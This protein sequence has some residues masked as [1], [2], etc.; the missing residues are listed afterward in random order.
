M[1]A[2]VSTLKLINIL[3]ILALIAVLGAIFWP[4]Y[5]R[6][7]P[8]TPATFCLSN[9]KQQ[10][11]AF[12]MYIA[13]SDEKFPNRDRWMDELFPYV[14]NEEIYR[15]PLWS[16]AKEPRP[17][18]FAFNSRL[19]NAKAP[20]EIGTTPVVYDSVNPIRNASDPAVSLPSP[21][22]HKGKNNIAYADGHAKSIAMGAPS[23]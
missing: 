18:G 8:L 9:I 4:V 2:R 16:K 13:D 12:Q 11:I 17:Y 7:R 15:E 22:R 5:S 23:Q 10:G 1:K 6:G 19:S 14:K 21:A 3:A 20:K